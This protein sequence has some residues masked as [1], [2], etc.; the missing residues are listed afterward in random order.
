MI[1]R[2]SLSVRIG[3]VVLLGVLLGT[4]MGAKP[5]GEPVN[6][7]G[8]GREP[9]PIEREF[10]LAPAPETHWTDSQPARPRP[11]QPREELSRL[12]FAFQWG[13]PGLALAVSGD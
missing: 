4:L 1:R 11:R 2:L 8:T 7:H 12:I 10:H 9:S 3:S 13:L 5:M 6:P